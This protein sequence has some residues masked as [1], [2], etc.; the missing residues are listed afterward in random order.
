MATRFMIRSL[1]TGLM[2]FILAGS[3]ATA[4]DPAS[5][6]IDVTRPVHRI[7]DSLWGIFFE[8]INHAGEGGLY[9]ELVQ[10]RDFEASI[11][12]EGWRVDGTNIY[13]PLGRK[14]QKW[15][16]NDLPE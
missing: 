5:I 16:A 2:T 3:S 8:D 9:A 7:P 14:V 6:S 10:N 15:F 12:P 4:A 11:I 1:A 13:T